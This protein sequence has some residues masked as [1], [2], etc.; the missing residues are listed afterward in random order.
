MKLFSGLLLLGLAFSNVFVAVG[1]AQAKVSVDVYYPQ[2]EKTN[3][4]LKLTGTIQAK[5]NSELATL[6]DGLIEEIFV[7]AGDIVKKGETLI[8]LDSTLAELVLAEASAEQRASQIVLDEAERRYKEVLSLSKNQ[9][10]AETLIAERRASF[11]EAEADLIRRKASVKLQQEVVDRHILK[12]P[13]A[14]VIAARNADNGEWVTRQHSVFNLVEQDNLRLSVEIPQEYYSLLVGQQVPVLVNPDSNKA[15]QYQAKLDRLVKIS[16]SQSRSF[17]GHIYLPQNAELV[18][19]MSARA[20]IKLPTQ[21][22]TMIWL[23]RAAI[24]QHPDGGNSVFA[25]VND[26]AKR[27]LVNIVEQ[28]NDRVAVTNASADYGYVISGVEVLRDDAELQI[29]NKLGRL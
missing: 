4:V 28:E 25:V 10:V 22:Q 27:V 20:E 18:A 12:A 2:K 19:G 14:G 16:K 23:P 6:V 24:K 7:E 29:S 5:Q 11:A 17:T 13:F 1:H 21:Q 26:K 3:Q 8:A 9:V 15:H